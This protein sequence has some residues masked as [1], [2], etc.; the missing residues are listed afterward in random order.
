[1]KI[2]KMLCG[3]T[4]FLI[5]K[6]IQRKMQTDFK[7]VAH[8]LFSLCLPFV[9][10]I[11]TWWG[12][13]NGSLAVLDSVRRLTRLVFRLSFSKGFVSYNCELKKKR[14]KRSEL[15]VNQDFLRRSKSSNEFKV[16]FP[17]STE[18]GLL[19]IVMEII[20]EFD[21]FRSRNNWN[22]NMLEFIAV[23]NGSHWINY[24][25]APKCRI[26]L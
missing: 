4:D 23:D 16:K 11:N 9:E 19:W 1:M 14:K 10:G 22:I 8:A 5:D 12:A 15:L 13:F 21:I 24:F 17:L 7:I 2:C 6:Q 3:R 25:C 20:I 18:F 26:W